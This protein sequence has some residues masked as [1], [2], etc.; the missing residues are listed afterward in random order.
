M[1]RATKMTRNDFLSVLGTEDHVQQYLGQRLGHEITPVNG[2]PF[3]GFSFCLSETQRVALG[4]DGN[5]PLGLICNTQL[6][7]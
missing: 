5:A 2:T 6:A 3:Q 4:C 1:Q 7:A